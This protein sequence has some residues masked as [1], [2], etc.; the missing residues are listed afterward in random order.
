MHHQFDRSRRSFLKASAAAAAGAAIFGRATWAAEDDALGGLKL[1]I[2]SYTL[3]DRNFEQMLQ[4]MKN[5]LKLHWV[6]LFGAHLSEHA[7]PEQMEQ[8][9]QK[10]KDADVT[11]PSFGVV[12]FSKNQDANRKL[13]EFAKAMGM[14]NIAANPDRDAFDSLDKLVDEYGITIAIHDHGP[15]AKWVKVQQIW[16]A[17]KDH[18]PKIG[19]CN[20]TGHFI[21][22]GEDPIEACHVFKSRMYDMHLKDFKPN[23]SGG[24]E[25]VPLGDGKLDVDGII[26]LL[27]EHHYPHGLFIEYEGGNPVPSTQKCVERV[28][29]AVA[30]AR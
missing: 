6:E 16:E 26:K 30:K 20:D 2:Q 25:D 28:K 8:A 5:D 17:V 4:A 9:K 24:W 12:D 22:A 21:R 13:F 14:K 27:L 10:L 19:L 1:G 18:N 23:G 15:G 29:Q 11:A 7:S 3:R